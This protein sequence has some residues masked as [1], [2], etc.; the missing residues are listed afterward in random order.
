MEQRKLILE[1]HQKGFT[2]RQIAKT[3]GISH[4]TVQRKY[5][6]PL[7]LEANGPKK[8][9]LRKTTNGIIC[10]KCNVEK[11]ETDFYS[12]INKNGEIKSYV[13]CI[14]CTKRIQLASG[15]R[16]L[17]SY[18][19]KFYSHVK[20]RAKL[21]DIPF[22]LTVQDIKDLYASQQG[23]CF[24]SDIKMEWGHGKGRS[25]LSLSLDRIIPQNGYTIGN[26]VLCTNKVNYVKSDV[27]LEELKD[28]MPGWYQRVKTF[29]NKDDSSN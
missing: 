4:N 19:S 29:W 15:N 18:L 24:Y 8:I 12:S 21:R 25:K 23:L 6:G 28:W 22:S 20:S 2:N 5:L 27:S 13:N 17:D 26:V 9:G 7:G 14:D 11:P 10:N 1:L 16:T 3:I